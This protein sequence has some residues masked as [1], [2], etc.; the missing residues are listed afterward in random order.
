MKIQ[1]KILLGILF[2]SILALVSGGTGLWQILRI[3]GQINEI[4]DTITPTIETA[5]DVVYYATEMQKLTIEMLAD[6]ELADIEVLYAEFQDANRN[7]D[8][9]LDELQGISSDA[10][11]TQRIESVRARTTGFVAAALEMREAHLAELKAEIDSEDIQRLLDQ[12][13]DEIAQSLL[14]LSESNEAEMA[15]AEE[16][17]DILAAKSTTT[18]SQMNDLLGELFE[19]DYPVVEAALKLQNLVNSIEA[20]VGEFMASESAAE[21]PALRD[22]FAAQV[23][24]TEQWFKALRD[25]AESASDNETIASIESQFQSWTGLANNPGMIFDMHI[26]MLQQEVLADEKAEEVDVI[27][28]ELVDEINIIIDAADALSDGADEKAAVLVQSATFIMMALGAAVI[29]TGALLSLT[30]M[31]TAMQP[32]NKIT[33]LMGQLA[34]GKLDVDVPFGDRKDEIGKIAK[35]VEVFKANGLKVAAMTEEEKMSLEHRTQERA[36]MMQGLQRAFGTVVDA[37]V[38][39]DFSQ[40]VEANFPDEA[41]NNLARGVNNLVE[42]VD[43]GMGETGEVL[44]ALAETDLTKRVSGEYQGAFLKLK[45]DTNAV[46]DKLADIV[47]QLRG[48]SGSLKSATG[49]ILAGANDLSE[50]T[51]RQAATIEETSASMEQLSVTVVE[52]AEKAEAATE[53]TNYASQ[54]ATEGGDVMGQATEAMER[55]T[56]SS[57]KISN[58]IGMIDD[59]AFQTNLLALNAS[60]EAA[61]AGEAGKGFAVVAVE[62]RRLAQSAAEASAEVKSLIEQSADE[63]SG[64]SKLVAL[65]SEKLEAMLGAV[66]ENAELI[67]DIAKASKDQATSIEEVGAAVR[68]MDEMTQHNA[69]LVEQTNAAIEQTETQATE[70]DQIVEVFTIEGQAKSVDVPTPSAEP[71]PAKASSSSKAAYLSQGNAAID[72]EWSE[73]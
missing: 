35:A 19:N 58:I 4:S 45:N 11:V 7:Y 67:V 10:E 22:H 5:D 15:A 9:A 25:N 38:A 17:G 71:K 16:E 66:K 69:A 33:E 55:I 43:R 1:S 32:L 47:G 49:E 48:T 41:L 3:E 28:D 21:L 8:L 29:A 18:A 64:G 53:K 51:T 2:V 68:T 31:K 65:A 59:I 34:T 23:T 63:V 73:F 50:R 27:G 42:T 24:E 61:R 20:S 37:S 30:V 56:T 26:G 39:G 62:V 60:V 54:L 40:R 6:E 12:N 70:L 72:S 44:A 36:E 57:S 52:N 14:Q 46:A 13:G